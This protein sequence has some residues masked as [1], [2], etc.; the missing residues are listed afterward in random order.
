ML[1]DLISEQIIK[2][3]P[4]YK[5]LFARVVNGRNIWDNDLAISLSV[6]KPLRA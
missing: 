4:A 1:G 5:I 2:N 6:L 3:A